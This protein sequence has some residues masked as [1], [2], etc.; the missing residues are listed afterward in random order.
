MSSTPVL[1]APDAPP[2]AQGP[3]RRTVVG[4]GLWSA[5]V[6]AMASSAPAFA[7]ASGQQALTLSVPTSGIPSSGPVQ[8]TTVVRD[9]QGAPVAGAPVSL[10][11]PLGS[12]F[13][14]ADGVTDGA[15]AYTTSFDLGKPWATPGSTISITAV[16]GGQSASQPF[17]VLG[18][19]VLAFG[20]NV[21]AELGLGA[22]ASSPTQTYRA[23]PSPVVQIAS[24]GRLTAARR[25]P[26][27][28]CC[29]MEPCGVSAV[30]RTGSWVMV[31]ATARVTM[32]GRS[33]PV[34]RA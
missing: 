1:P 28:R 4:A 32:C 16:S 9:A 21:W 7:A 8:L 3:S 6:L 11:G 25:E 30:T 27:W 34:C 18:S 13:G 33:S 2:L 24:G 10:S 31:R 14:G 15:G 17:T 22:A 5:P 29:E 12:T 26:R 20:R 23:F 19:N